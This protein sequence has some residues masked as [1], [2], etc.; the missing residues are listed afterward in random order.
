MQKMFTILDMNM[1]EK[2]ILNEWNSFEFES[3]AQIRVKFI[4]FK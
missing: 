3:I 1:L 4:Q 2:A